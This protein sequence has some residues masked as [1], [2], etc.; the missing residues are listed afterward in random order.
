[1]LLGTAAEAAAAPLA[2]EGPTGERFVAAAA[3]RHSI[4]TIPAIVSIGEAADAAA[5]A[6]VANRT[7][8]GL[9]LAAVHVCTTQAIDDADLRVD[10]YRRVATTLGEVAFKVPPQQQQV[11]ALVAIGRDA[12]AAPEPGETV[13][14]AGLHQVLATIL[15]APSLMYSFELGDVSKATPRDL[16]PHELA[17]RLSLTILGRNPTR[18]LLDTAASGG[19]STPAQVKAVVTSMLGEPEAQEA[20]WDMVEEWFLI[21]LF[22][23]QTR[24]SFSFFESIRSDMKE[25]ARRFAVDHVFGSSPLPFPQL[26]SSQRRFITAGLANNIYTQQPITLMPDA[27]GWS[28]INFNDYHDQRR[29][30]MITLPAFLTVLASDYRTKIVARGKYLWE[31]VLCGALID[32]PPQ[33]VGAV[34]T[35]PDPPDGVTTWR[36]LMEGHGTSGCGAGCHSFMDPGGLSLEHFNQV[37]AYRTRDFNGLGGEIDAVTTVV[38]PRTNFERVI[39]DG[40]DFGKLMADPTFPDS[41]QFIDNTAR[42]QVLQLSEAMLGE[43]IQNNMASSDPELLVATQP[44][45]NLLGALPNFPQYML[46]DFYAEFAA[47]P[48]VLQVGPPR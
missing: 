43:Q 9:P 35:P 13:F 41:D 36:I 46:K 24:P 19:L 12:E 3:V 8:T 44:L 34:P 18:D 1:M 31:R 27:E 10:C 37:G 15:Q 2:W 42:C 17:T 25:E 21:D 23:R 22:D 33:G 28:L 14:D 20:Y 39:I 45:N 47:S 29:S 30:G 48:Y 6:A 38:H 5:G 40:L 16:L 26:L 11:D 4:G 7:N 32:L